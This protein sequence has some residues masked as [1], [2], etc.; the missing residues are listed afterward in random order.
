MCRTQGDL[1]IQVES[2]FKIRDLAGTDTKIYLKLMVCVMREK[3]RMN[4]TFICLYLYVDYLG[5]SN[6]ILHTT[7]GRVSIDLHMLTTWIC[8]EGHMVGNTSLEE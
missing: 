7:P 6:H 2:S 1:H 5:V 8:P 4:L 3:T